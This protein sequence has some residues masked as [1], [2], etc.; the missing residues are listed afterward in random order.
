[1]LDARDGWTDEVDILLCF[2]LVED[3]LL[4]PEKKR[5]F[6]NSYTY[7]SLPKMISLENILGN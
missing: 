3:L 1:M 6:R 4:E 5:V 7:L 2:M